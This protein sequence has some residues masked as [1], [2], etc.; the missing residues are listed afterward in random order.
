LKEFGITRKE[1][2]NGDKHHENDFIQQNIAMAA[3]IKHQ[4]HMR[5]MFRKT[6]LNMNNVNN[7]IA[8]L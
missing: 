1:V 5:K 4:E 2:K 3:N 7:T 6:I 8:R